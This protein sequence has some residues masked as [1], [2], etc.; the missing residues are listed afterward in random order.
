[1]PTLFYIMTLL[2]KNSYELQKAQNL[3]RVVTSSLQPSSCTLPQQLR[4]LP[5]EYHINIK[6]ISL[7]ALS[8]P[9]SLPIYIQPSALHAYRPTCSLRLSNT[10]LSLFRLF[11]LHLAPAASALQLLKSALSPSSS[12]N[13]YQPRHFSSSPQDSLFPT[14]L[15]IRLTPYSCASGS[16]SAD[17][18]ARLQIVFTY[19]GLLTY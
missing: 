12:S 1:M 4:W 2:R 7:S 3:A 17:H 6:P 14:G 19:F 8:I 16:T 13:V 18:W 10:N 11:A 15:S 5:T 9:L